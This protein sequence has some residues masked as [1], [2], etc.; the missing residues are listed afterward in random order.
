MT[1]NVL[2]LVNNRESSKLPLLEFSDFFPMILLEEALL[3]CPRNVT[4]Y[5]EAGQTEKQPIP[6]KPIK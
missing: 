3:G 4:T 6:N 5:E 2:F 1:K